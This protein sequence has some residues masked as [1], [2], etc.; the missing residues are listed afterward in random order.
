MRRCSWLVSD[1]FARLCHW[2]TCAFHAV[3]MRDRYAIHAWYKRYTCG[4]HAGF[5]RVFLRTCSLKF[6]RIYLILVYIRVLNVIDAWLIRILFVIHQ[7]Y[8]CRNVAKYDSETC[9]WVAY[10]PF[11]AWIMRSSC[12]K[13][14]VSGLLDYRFR[15]W[16]SWTWYNWWYTWQRQESESGGQHWHSCPVSPNGPWFS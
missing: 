13:A 11:Y 1:T 12:G 9:E 10:R 16:P 15:S 14:Y 3:Y 2:Y 4:I 5:E 8:V 6:L 7:W